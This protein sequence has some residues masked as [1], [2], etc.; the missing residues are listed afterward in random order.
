MKAKKNSNKKEKTKL[1]KGETI[2]IASFTAGLVLLVT[3]ITDIIGLYTDI[4]PIILVIISLILGIVYL[5]ILIWTEIT[6]KSIVGNEYISNFSDYL[7]IITVPAFICEKSIAG[8][9]QNDLE[10]KILFSIIFAAFFVGAIAL[11]I[12]RLYKKKGNTKE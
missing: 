6:G 12:P 4:K 5:A 3:I 9:L 2:K 10:G 1:N 8:S 7:T 11:T